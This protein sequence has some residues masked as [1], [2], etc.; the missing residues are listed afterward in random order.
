MAGVA[1]LS[2]ALAAK[3][4]APRAPL[5]ALVLGAYLIDLVFMVF[6]AAGKERIPSRSADEDA[7]EAGA[8]AAAL[9]AATGADARSAA[10]ETGTNPWS[11]GLLMALVWTALAGLV[12]TR[13]GRSRRTGF[14]F[15]LLVFSHWIVD[16]VTKPMIGVFPR[17]TG[18]P[19]LFEGSPTV[20]LGLYRWQGVAN[21][22]EYGSLAVGLALYVQT[23]LQQR[24]RRGA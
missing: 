7:P 24:R 13:V 21:V 17:D 11:H 8:D 16:F 22:V 23:V 1:H 6:M 5:W 9:D 14:F 3:R 12:A 20:G 10:A 2:V 18:L 19:L 4:V 15:A